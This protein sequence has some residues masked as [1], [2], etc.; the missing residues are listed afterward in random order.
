[1][2][3]VDR[4]D[5]TASAPASK[6]RHRKIISAT[7]STPI[8]RTIRARQ[9]QALFDVPDQVDHTRS[10]EISA[11]LAERPWS[12]GAVI[13]PSGSGKTTILRAFGEPLHLDWSA[14]SMIDDF[15][16]TQ[17]I[18]EIADAC[19]A[20][21]FST[22]PAWLRPFRVLSNGEQFRATMARLMIESEGLVLVDEFTSVV[23]RQVAKIAAYATQRY[24]RRQDRQM[25]IASCHEDVIDWL[26]P[27]WI[28]RPDLETFD[29]RDVS[30]RPKL[31]LKSRP[32]N[33]RSGAGSLHFTI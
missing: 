5:S 31:I 16:S 6:V 32:A 15:S 33:M 23:D 30:P 1:M 12:V 18:S 4:L 26:Q 8:S 27:D 19:S 3:A 11:P 2:S 25:I 10:W 24:V 14:A 28:I 17:G 22:I 9:L 7:V 13:G 20:V 29:W 21:G